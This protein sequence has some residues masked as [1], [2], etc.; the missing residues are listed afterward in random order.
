[1]TLRFFLVQNRQGKVRLAKWYM[2]YEDEEKVKLSADIHRL[3]NGRNS[4]WTNFTE[5]REHKLVY[6]RYAGLFFCVCVAPDANELLAL[7]TIHLIVETLDSYF[8]NVCELHLVFNFN[9]VYAILDEVV[10][11]G[12][13][14]ETSKAKI[15][16]R[17]DELEDLP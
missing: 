14:V 7:E 8:A 16:Q 4:K 12:E 2:P 5:F 17:V 3:V 1:M 6:R 9:K 15:L 13:V 10:I 11:G